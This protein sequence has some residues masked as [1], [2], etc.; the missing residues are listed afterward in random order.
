MEDWSDKDME[1][2]AKAEQEAEDAWLRHAEN[3]IWS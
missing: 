3:G 2:F 1:A